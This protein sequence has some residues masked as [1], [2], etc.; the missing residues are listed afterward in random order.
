MTGIFEG[1]KL[2]LEACSKQCQHTANTAVAA[3]G[4]INALSEGAST[5]VSLKLTHVYMQP[6]LG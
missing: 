2:Q 4:R 3:L 1:E 5:E 6:Q